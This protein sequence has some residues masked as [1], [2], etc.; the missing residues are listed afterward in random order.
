MIN[1]ITGVP[2]K[3]EWMH[4]TAHLR[5]YHTLFRRWAGAWWQAEDGV[6]AFYFWK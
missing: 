3:A 2:S 6:S 4:I 1:P 5:R